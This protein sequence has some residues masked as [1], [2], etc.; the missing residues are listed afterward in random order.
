MSK[1]APFAHWRQAAQPRDVNPQPP[2]DQPLLPPVFHFSQNSLQDY[3]DCA[4]RFQLRYV[5]GQQWPAAATEPIEEYERWMQQGAEFHL[6]VQRHLL[7]IP[8]D[9]L[10]PADPEVRTW[11]ADFE[12]CPVPDLPTTIREPE[13]MMSTPLDGQRI[14]ARF[15]LL[16]IDPGQ[17]VVIVDWKTARYRP[18]RETLAERLQSHVYP[19]VL[20]EAG[21]HLF[22]GPIAPE[23]ISLIY[24]FAQDASRPEIFEYSAERHAENCA[25]LSR[26]IS[27]VYSW[28]QDVWPLTENLSHCEYCVYRSLC[29]RGV[30]AGTLDRLPVDADEQD[31]AFS[32]ELDDVD[33]IAF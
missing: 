20:A 13:I 10:V 3:V 28:Q 24:W 16:A 6:L 26:L 8:A 31:F 23:Q 18:T 9:K 11:W 7:G 29:D 25:Y 17:R 32:L 5:L 22:G 1:P 15:D 2:A 27:E 19:F 14:L 30:K 12:R 33:E 4:R 21:S